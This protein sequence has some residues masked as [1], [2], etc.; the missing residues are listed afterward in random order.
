MKRY[1]SLGYWSILVCILLCLPLSGVAADDAEMGAVPVGAD[2]ASKVWV[3]RHPYVPSDTVYAERSRHFIDLLEL[4]MSKSGVSYVLEAVAVPPVPSSRNMLFLN[5]GKY[6]V[7]WM[8][9]DAER[10][11]Q[12]LPIRVPIYRGIGGWRLGFILAGKEKKYAQIKTLEQLQQLTLGQGHDW[13][14]TDILRNAGFE[15]REGVSRDS[16]FHLLRYRRVDMFPRGVNEIWD[17][18][19]LPDA[20]GLEIENTI[21]I[22]YPT[23]FYFFVGHDN[24][25]LAALLRRGFD[26]AIADGSFQKL[27][28]LYFGEPIK[29]ARLDQRRI[30]ELSNPTLSPE[31]PLERPELWYRIGEPLP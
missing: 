8:H 11:R 10:E 22:H 21:A 7:G 30:F 5:S 16:V 12:L 29:K 13:P 25:D 3:V 2:L 14:D 20:H 1:L 15:V 24:H 26:T 28:L 4:V 17:E 19:A 18:L 9:A 27:F 31:T 23:A 6:D